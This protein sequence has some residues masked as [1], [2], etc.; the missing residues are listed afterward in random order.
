MHETTSLPANMADPVTSASNASGNQQP[1]P[2]MQVVHSQVLNSNNDKC[3]TWVLA[4]KNG[5]LYIAC[6]KGASS[7][8]ALENADPSTWTDPAVHQPPKEIEIASIF[9]A[10]HS[11]YTRFQP[12]Q[13]DISHSFFSKRPLYLDL[14]ARLGITP[15][16]LPRCRTVVAREIAMCER[17]RVHPHPNIVEYH[18]VLSSNAVGFRTGLGTISVP[19][20]KERVTCIIYKRYDTTLWDFV[21]TRTSSFNVRHCLESIAKSIEHLHSVGIVHN[22]IKPHNVFVTV[23]DQDLPEAHH[24][25]L[26]DYDSA[27]APGFLLQLKGG[28]TPWARS[29]VIGVDIVEESDDWYGFLKVKEWLVKETGGVLTQFEDVGKTVHDPVQRQ[30]RDP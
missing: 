10:H 28:T 13:G 9:P 1:L 22:D 14:A 29:K 8:S 23:K 12:Q 20:D 27:H 18:G 24:W 5:K 11:S 15:N 2:S 25:V 3:E 7:M 30:E 4:H 19:L 21:M 26:G 6:Q 17:L 16:T